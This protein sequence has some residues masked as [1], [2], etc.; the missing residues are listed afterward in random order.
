MTLD[1]YRMIVVS[2]DG[3]TYMVLLFRNLTGYPGM[4]GAGHILH[5]SKNGIM[6]STVGP[7]LSTVQLDN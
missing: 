4:L 1:E 7:G 5:S 6:I 3:S 2:Y